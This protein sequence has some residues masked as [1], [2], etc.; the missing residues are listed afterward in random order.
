MSRIAGRQ[1]EALD[2]DGQKLYDEI[3]AARGS[4][5]GPFRVWLHSPSSRGAR[6][7]AAS[8]YV[9]TRVCRRA[10]ANSLF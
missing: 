6:L 9:T 8:F 1:R 10:S 2:A 4:I 7:S 3:L 5:A